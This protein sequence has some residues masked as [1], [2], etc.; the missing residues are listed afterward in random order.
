MW[1][2][3]LRFIEDRKLARE[4][5]LLA[6][7]GGIDSM[8]M[9]HLFIRSEIRIGVAHCNFGLRG[10]ESDDDEAFVRMCCKR[11]RLPVYSRKLDAMKV[12]EKEGISIQMAARTL[13]YDYFEK[14]R[15]RYGYQKVA[16]AHHL[17]DAAETMLLNL[18]RGAGVAGMHG[19]VPVRGALIRPMLFATRKDIRSFARREKIE[20]REDRSNRKTHYRRNLVRRKVMPVL[21]EINPSVLEAFRLHGEIAMD[22]GHLLAE[23]VELL[24]KKIVIRKGNELRIDTRKLRSHAGAPTLLF[25]LIRS[26]GFNRSVC[27]DIY[28]SLD[29]PPGKIFLSG[30]YRILRDRTHLLLARRKVSGREEHV[31]GADQHH[32]DTSHG[33]F[34]IRK[35][36]L[37]SDM[38]K[39][40]VTGRLGDPNVAWLDMARLKFPLH[41]RKW[42]KGDTFRPLGMRGKMKLSDFFINNKYSVTRKAATWLL[43]SGG[44][45]AWVTGDRIDDRFKVTAATQNC[46]EVIFEAQ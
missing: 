8:V 37:T 39:N 21:A 3:F 15:K 28:R 45:I 10:G 11:N 13:R 27:E 38:K 18:V 20:W 16:T 14:L 26:Y 6:V 1:E 23:Y 33:T 22:T 32:I 31:I 29:G 43:V 44:S 42:E 30:D 46:L 24:R 40:I 19:I 7:S 34:S 12:S 17:D 35:L 2:A 4:K 25:E 36:A 9:L 5:V 41:L